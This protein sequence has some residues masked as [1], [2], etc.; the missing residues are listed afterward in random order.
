V[1]S[2][3]FDRQ[4]QRTVRLFKEDDREQSDGNGVDVGGSLF[5]VWAARYGADDDRT[6]IGGE[7]KRA[8][9]ERAGY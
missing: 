3:G 5:S 8:G 1:G 9:S 4:V 7:Q 6:E 2:E